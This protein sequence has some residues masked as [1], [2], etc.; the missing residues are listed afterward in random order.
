MPGG[1]IL[2]H[3]HP[4]QEERFTIIVGEA[5]F[6]VRGEKRVVGPGETIVVPV[7]IRQSE[8]NRG[9]VAIEGVVELRPATT[10]ELDSGQLSLVTHPRQITEL[11]F[12]AARHSG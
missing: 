11:I 4:H 1:T 12:R 2:E 5:H 7:G 10:T 6:T 3:T 8:P 9:S